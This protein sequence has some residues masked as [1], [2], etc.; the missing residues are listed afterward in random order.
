[1]ADVPPTLWATAPNHG[2]AILGVRLSRGRMAYGHGI[3]DN[4]VRM[5]HRHATFS[6]I[7]TG[8]QSWERARFLTRV[9][10][11]GASL[12][13]RLLGSPVSFLLTPRCVRAATQQGET[14]SLPSID[15][16]IPTRLLSHWK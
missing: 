15:A 2:F 9:R 3:V 1:M 14:V 5:R 12:G 16:S 7:V 10:E 8:C 6:S 11:L 13:W 4:T